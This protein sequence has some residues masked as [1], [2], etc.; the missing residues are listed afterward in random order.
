MH[1][2]KLELVKF[3]IIANVFTFQ[4]HIEHEQNVIKNT[5]CANYYYIYVWA[6]VEQIY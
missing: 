1:N 3:R 5:N 2:G 6:Y 4:N